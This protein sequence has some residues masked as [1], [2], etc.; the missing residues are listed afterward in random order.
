MEYG[1]ALILTLFTTFVFPSISTDIMICAATVALLT[2]GILATL[3]L[4]LTVSPTHASPRPI[5]RTYANG[6]A[7][8]STDAPPY[9]PTIDT[10]V[11]PHPVQRDANR[12][13][14]AGPYPSNSK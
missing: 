1:T 12:W 5:T 4:V 13:T 8:A 14:A 11:Y 2:T 10:A 7:T 3:L 9:F 6:V